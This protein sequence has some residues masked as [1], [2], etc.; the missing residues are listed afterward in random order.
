[1]LKLPS[2]HYCPE[3]TSTLSLSSGWMPTSPNVHLAHHPTQDYT[4]LY[5]HV[6]LYKT[7][8]PVFAR[9]LKDVALNRK[10]QQHPESPTTSI[11]T[12]KK[13]QCTPRGNIQKTTAVS[14]AETIPANTWASSPSPHILTFSE[15]GQTK[16]TPAY[17]LPPSYTAGLWQP[18]LCSDCEHKTHNST[19]ASHN[20]RAKRHPSDAQPHLLTPTVIGQHF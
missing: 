3:K 17:P 19:S 10:S 9:T 20:N 12:C 11:K 6:H 16:A 5:D 15:S 13:A 14:H 2:P 18:Q 4:C 1:M 7:A 8:V